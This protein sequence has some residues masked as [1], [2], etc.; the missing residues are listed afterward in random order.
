MPKHGIFI[1]VTEASPLKTFKSWVL[2]N[3]Q[4][5]LISFPKRQKKKN[6]KPTPDAFPRLTE[7]IH[8]G[9]LLFKRIYIR[10]AYKWTSE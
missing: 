7:Y 5:Q 3:Y 2:C 10:Y 6:N 1:T 4:I 8:R 9:P